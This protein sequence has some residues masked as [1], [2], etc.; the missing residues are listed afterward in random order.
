MTVREGNMNARLIWAQNSTDMPTQ[1]TR[2]TRLRA[3]SET[4][5]FR[6]IN[7][8]LDLDLGCGFSVRGMVPSASDP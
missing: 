7:L 2:F 5:E 6:F 8:D 1:M 3:L 4:F